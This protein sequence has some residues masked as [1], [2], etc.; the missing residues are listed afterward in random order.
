MKCDSFLYLKL[1]IASL[2]T[3][4]FVGWAGAQEGL[5]GPNWKSDP[6]S[7]YFFQT[8]PPLFR[9]EHAWE[10]DPEVNVDWTL[11][12]RPANL[13]LDSDTLRNGSKHECLLGTR[14]IIRNIEMRN[15]TQAEEVEAAILDRLRSTEAR[16]VTFRS[17]LVSAAILM[18]DSPED[19]ESLWLLEESNYETRMLVEKALLDSRSSVAISAWRG[20]MNQRPR[21]LREQLLAVQ[22][23]GAHGDPSDLPALK[24]CFFSPTS[25]LPIQLAAAQS[26]GQLAT[27]GL[28]ATAREALAEKEKLT[29]QADLTAAYMLKKHNSV[30]SAEVLGR[31]LNSS[32]RAA[33]VTAFETLTRHHPKIAQ[34]NLKQFLVHPDPAA[35]RLALRFAV[36][37]DAN[38]SLGFLQEALGDINLKTR[39]QARTHLA[40]LATDGSLK[41]GVAEAAAKTLQENDPLAIEQ[42][43]IL[44]GEAKLSSLA[45][46]MI[47]MLDAK[48]EAT[49]VAAAWAL[50]SLELD[51][52]SLQAVEDRMRRLT[53]RN[54]ASKNRLPRSDALQLSYLIDTLVINRVDRIRPLLDQFIPKE[55][56][57]PPPRAAA[58]WGLGIFEAGSQDGKLAQKL[59]ERLHDADPD[60]PEE[61]IIKYVSAIAMGRILHPSSE[62]QLDV[63]LDRPP[64]PIGLATQWGLQ[65]FASQSDGNTEESR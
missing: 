63:H 50:Q 1:I 65:Q 42:V 56:A 64:F 46:G 58:I 41:Q 21:S 32:N 38:S 48:P 17:A 19:L 15:I 34:Q 6:N 11:R 26:M 60:I 4:C 2:G 39:S 52:E 62:E 24:T 40:A 3:L 14:Q 28:E 22:G 59:A 45:A 36:E 51:A 61:T 31:I 53:R 10:H 9:L 20:R 5:R 47:E 57:A 44:V 13:S 29:G 12:G 8:H 35:R 16:D 33:Q 7:A 18:A 27:K 54:F 49:L 37:S 55:D 25:V 43:C 23:L 30:E